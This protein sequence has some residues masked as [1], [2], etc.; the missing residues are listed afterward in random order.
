[1]KEMTSVTRLIEAYEHTD[2][3]TDAIVPDHAGHDPDTSKL[4]AS[5]VV[6]GHWEMPTNQ[7]VLTL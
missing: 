4:H 6:H 1:M 3:Q 5:I 7:S 2:W